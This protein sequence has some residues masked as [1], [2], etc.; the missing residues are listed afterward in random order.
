MASEATASEDTASE[1]STSPSNSKAES[2]DSSISSVSQATRPPTTEES[3]HKRYRDRDQ[4][5]DASQTS[6]NSSA[7]TTAS[8]TLS[9]QRTGRLSVSSAK[10]REFHKILLRHQ[11]ESETKEARSSERISHI[12]RQLHRFDDLDNKLSEVRQDTSQRFCLFE[13]RRLESIKTHIDQPST[14][15]EC[16]R[17]RMEQLMTAMES[18]ID[19]SG[20]VAS[21]STTHQDSIVQ[22]KDTGESITIHH[23]VQAEIMG[24]HRNQVHLDRL[25]ARPAWAQKVQV[26]WTLSLQAIY[27]LRSIN[28]NDR[29]ELRNHFMKTTS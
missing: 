26:T 16:M 6:V 13:D 12:E 24:L 10:F 1:V 23:D 3:L 25:A 20:K 18:A 2:T 29:A 14:D 15:T 4:T 22:N 8:T 21:T 19:N 11:Q 9:N 28:A 5:S 7:S 27:N 17:A